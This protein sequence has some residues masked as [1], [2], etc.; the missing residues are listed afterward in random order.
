M[1]SKRALALTFAVLLVATQQS[2]FGG[3][4]PLFRAGTELVDLYVT[5]T[6]DNGRLVPDLVQAD[7]AVFDE[8]A[9]QEIA[10]FEN[11]VRPITVVLMLDTSISTT[12][13]L[14]LIVGGAEQFLIRM[15]P[16]D[17]ARI[18]AFNDKIQ[19]SPAEFVGD[20]DALIGE[21]SRLDYGNETRLFDALSAGLDALRTVAGRKVILVLTDGDDS[22][23]SIGWR[24]VLERAVSEEVMIY[25]IGLEVEYF[26]GVRNRRTSP[27]RSLRRLAE[28]TGGGYFLLEETDDLG[29]TFTRVS[30][31]LHSQYVL[32][33]TPTVRDGETHSVEVRVAGRGME[34]RSRR[35]YVAPS[36]DIVENENR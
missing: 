31:E 10:L 23:S 14:H 11:E 7:F 9:P 22:S 6:D 3:Q 27:D 18:G 36:D 19:I 20:R 5:V 24:D 29:P 28:E 34:A 33:F 35:S 17:E 1:D 30:Q 26:D 8:E 12:N 15:L 16:D 25:S 2:M 4:Q 13:V 21:L 32:G